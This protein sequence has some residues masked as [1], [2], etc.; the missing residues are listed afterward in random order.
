MSRRLY[1]AVAALLLVATA[2]GLV[3]ASERYNV[4]AGHGLADRDAIQ[5]FEDDGV[6]RANVSTPHLTLTIAAQADACGVES[7]LWSDARNDFLCVEYHNDL[8]QTTRLFVP[9]DYWTPIVHQDKQAVGDGPPASFQPVHEGNYTSVTIRFDGSGQAVYPIPRDVST[10]YALINRIND[11]TRRIAGVELWSG[12]TQWRYVNR[13]A[14]GTSPSVAIKTVPDRTM[15]EY[16]ATPDRAEQTWLPVPSSQSRTAPV[17]R[18]QRSNDTETIYVI[19]EADEPPAIRYRA[20][21]AGIARVDAAI[22]EIGSV[23]EKVSVAVDRLLPEWLG[24][25]G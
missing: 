10:S 18:M 17:Y 1:V 14:F 8:A 4:D 19:S 22:D 9:D 24:G 23:P 2:A 3:A 15:I 5:S 21:G 13:S 7:S 11:R 16:D 25:S 12:G 20:R 6:A